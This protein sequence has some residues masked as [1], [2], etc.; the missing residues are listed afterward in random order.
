MAL[1]FRKTSGRYCDELFFL[2]LVADNASTSAANCSDCS[3][4]VMQIQL[5]SPFGYDDDFADDFKSATASC[6]SADYPFT[7]P[8]SYAVGTDLPNP[9]NDLSTPSCSRPY[10][11]PPGDSCDAISLSKEVST[12]SIIRAGGLR[13]DCSNLA[14]GAS[15][16]LPSPCSLDRV[17]KGDDCAS[18]VARYPGVTR[19]S[20]LSWNPNIDPICTNI[21]DLVGTFICL[22]SVLP[23]TSSP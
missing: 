6:S 20:L 21:A 14:A 23:S 13:P 17:R 1:C 5:N 11:V 18:I 22:T 7:S 2:W 15:L 8:N 16:C 10:L 4:G 9:G 19:E 12:Y 3:L